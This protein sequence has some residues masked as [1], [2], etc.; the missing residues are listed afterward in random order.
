MEIARIDV[1]IRLRRRNLKSLD[2]KTPR[3]VNFGAV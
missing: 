3:L 2:L 1:L